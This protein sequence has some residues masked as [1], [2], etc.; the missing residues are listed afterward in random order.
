MLI[1]IGLVVALIIWRPAWRDLPGVG[2]A[3]GAGTSPEIVAT[4]GDPERGRAA[5][6]SYGCITCH[7]IPGV[8]GGDGLVGPPLT[9]WADRVYV[10]G[11]LTNTPDHLIAWIQNPQA[12]APGNAMPNLGVS[13]SDARNIAAYLYTLHP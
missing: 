11:Y 8:P 12:V 6:V 5:L 2:S 10:G 13:D 4:G 7:T 9:N 3:S 1:L